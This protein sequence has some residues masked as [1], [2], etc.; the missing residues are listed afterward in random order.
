MLSNF[1]SEITK[2]SNAFTTSSSVSNLFLI[3]L[4]FKWQITVFLAC[5]ILCCI[6]LKRSLSVFDRD[7]D[8][9]K[10]KN[11][12]H[13]I[14][15]G[16]CHVGQSQIHS[17][18]FKKFGQNWIDL[19]HSSIAYLCLSVSSQWYY[20]VKSCQY[21]YFHRILQAECFLSQLLL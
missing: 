3:E 2:T 13:Q 7:R 14:G 10:K 5:S 9:L 1:Y 21:Q 16:Y 11:Y 6:I 18:K 19:Y 15:Y 17:K 20:H 8:H 12:W 4:V